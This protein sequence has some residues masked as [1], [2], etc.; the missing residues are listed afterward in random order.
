M[1]FS[2]DY[3][4]TRGDLKAKV[5]RH[6]ELGG[7]Q[8]MKF[9]DDAE[10][11]ATGPQPPK[12]VVEIPEDIKKYLDSYRFAMLVTDTEGSDLV[13]SDPARII[14]DMVSWCLAPGATALKSRVFGVV[15]S[16]FRDLLRPITALPGAQ[17]LQHMRVLASGAIYHDIIA[18]IVS[19]SALLISAP[20]R[21][22]SEVSVRAW[23]EKL[24]R[25]LPQH[26]D[27]QGLPVG[28]AMDSGMGGFKILGMTLIPYQALEDRFH[29]KHGRPLLVDGA[30]AL[31]PTL[32]HPRLV[33][34][35]V[36]SRAL[37]SESAE[38]TLLERSVVYLLMGGW[39]DPMLRK[40]G[41]SVLYTTA[42]RLGKE[43]D[44]LRSIEL[45]IL[46]MSMETDQVES[47][48]DLEYRRER[49]LA[50]HT[51]IDSPSDAAF[52]RYHFPTKA[53]KALLSDITASGV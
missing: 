45:D 26:Y 50:M 40:V 47:E 9:E 17:H 15:G 36:S 13:I 12:E 34:L 4:N 2:E 38:P 1:Y 33:S 44:I 19:A 10:E 7:E 31:I 39:M 37:R 43:A 20:D 29:A 28:S 24:E 46:L 52:F 22:E 41:E 6:Y 27:G 11:E 30:R 51:F 5:M 23:T 14:T 25:L 21:K 53:S 18:G 42:N 32:E 48:L 49:H 35:L 16:Y 3:K 8:Q